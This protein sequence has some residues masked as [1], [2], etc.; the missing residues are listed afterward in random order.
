MLT[1]KLQNIAGAFRIL[2]L[3]LHISLKYS[4]SIDPISRLQHRAPK[5]IPYIIFTLKMDKMGLHILW[6]M[7]RAEESVQRYLILFPFRFNDKCNVFMFAYCITHINAAKKKCDHWLLFDTSED[8]NIIVF[9][10][11]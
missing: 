1:L 11:P 4:E 10:A 7:Q 3:R 5:S 8:Y 9:I 6:P 2:P